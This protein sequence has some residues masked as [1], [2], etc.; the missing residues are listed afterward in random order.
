MYEVKRTIVTKGLKMWCKNAIN[1]HINYHKYT[2]LA[3]QRAICQT[4]FV[5]EISLC[6]SLRV[7]CH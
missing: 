7:S 4:V 3:Q 2:Y 6:P 1:T 5:F